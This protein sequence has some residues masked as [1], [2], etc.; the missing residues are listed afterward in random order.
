[1]NFVASGLRAIAVGAFSPTHLINEAAEKKYWK[2]AD[3]LGQTIKINNQDVTV[4][5]IVGNIRHLGPETPPRQEAYV[6]A[7][8][9]GVTNMTL[10]IRTRDEPLALLPTAL[11]QE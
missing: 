8:Q 11:R 7:S 9:N 3:A 4:V 6:P 10:A 5:G 1:M 2:G